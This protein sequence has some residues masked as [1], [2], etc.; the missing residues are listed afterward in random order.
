[1]DKSKRQSHIQHPDRRS[2]L[3]TAGVIAAAAASLPAAGVTAATPAR[4]QARTGASE[5]MLKGFTFATLRR[6]DGFGLALRTDRGVLDVVA[7]E[8]DFREGAPTSIDAVLKGQGDI[9]ALR[10]LVDK[11]RA[12]SAADRY[13]VAADKAAFG[14]CVTNPEKIVCV[15]LNYRRH[16]AE[17]GNPV[18]KQPILFNKFNTALNY[19]GGTIGVSEEDA[20]RFDYEAEL[21]IVIGRRARNISEADAPNYI[22]G[23]ATGN[24]FTARDLQ[25]RSSQWMLGKSLDGSAPVG[26]WLV[27]ADQVDGDNLKIEC[28]VNG[29]VRQSSNTSDM[30]FNCKQ[31]VSYASRYMTLKPGDIIFTGTPEG[32]ISGYPKDKQVW[33]KPG[34]KVVT[35]IEKLGDLTFTLT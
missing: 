3:K 18:P 34:D 10:R 32:V 21:V 22:F 12:S 8:L 35:S 25:S 29:E 24:D 33:L 14:P 11:A 26:P 13:F 20:K 7:A 9:N 31:L 28:R 2:L 1:M 19:E 23:Y 16:A 17:T 30:V 4:A 6:A 27:T 15:G 5:T